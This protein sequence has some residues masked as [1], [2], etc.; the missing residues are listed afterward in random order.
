M[1][2][3]ILTEVNGWTPVIDYIVDDLGLIT[4]NVFGMIWRYCQMKNGECTASQET[5]ANR[6]KVTRQTVSS[7]AEKLCQ[8]GYLEKITKTGIGVTYRD[9]GKATL[10]Q[11]IRAGIMDTCQNS[12]QLPVNEIDTTCQNG[13]H[14]DTIK[15]EIKDTKDN[16]CCDQKNPFRIYEQNIGVITPL[17][18]DKIDSL[19]DEID[20][21]FPSSNTSITWFSEAVKIAANQNVRKMSYIEGILKDWIAKGCMDTEK[22][23]NGKG[24]YSKKKEI[25]QEMEK[26]LEEGRRI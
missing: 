16:S 26:L 6:L 18:S 13:L 17:I 8:S 10:K 11:E 12:L 15:K 9:T 21:M 22:K 2:K 19:I 5:I 20:E 1:S 4:A 7:H 24:N 14:K 25:D 23:S 3:T